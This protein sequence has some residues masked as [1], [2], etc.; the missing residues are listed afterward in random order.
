MSKTVNKTLASGNNDYFDLFDYIDETKHAMVAA[1]MAS[2]TAWR[3]DTMIVSGA[4][5]LLKSIKTEMFNS[6][7]VESMNEA[8]V[9][10]EDQDFAE[11]SFDEIGT[12]P[13]ASGIIETLRMLNAQRDRWHD[14]AE[15]LTSMTSDYKGQPQMYVIPD[16][17]AAFAKDP[18][19][20]VNE[21]T[22]RRLKIR[23]ERMATALDAPELA[24][25][26]Y[27]RSIQR[28]KDDNARIAST[29]KD[30]AHLAQFMFSLALRTDEVG[31]SNRSKEFYDLPLAAQRM[32]LDN[33]ANAALRAD[34]RAA[35]DRNMT[36]T[37]YDMISLLAIKAMADMKKVMTAPRFRVQ[38]DAA[39]Q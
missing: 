12:S 29:L 27:E 8:I 18:A 26:H 2:S 17:D 19:L 21:T 39:T 5:Q 1:N 25:Q 16:I 36:E 3:I 9:C 38:Y 37:E 20:R 24:Q 34:E 22:Q 4:R 7:G 14:L 30:Q 11:K 35:D 33:A 13:E 6:G 15:R 28:K 10:L 23:S 32:L 31:A